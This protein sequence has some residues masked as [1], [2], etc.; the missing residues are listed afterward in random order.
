MVPSS[1]HAFLHC[2]SSLLFARQRAA[3]AEVP[4][5]HG[6]HV[7]ARGHPRVPRDAL[8]PLRRDRALPRPPERAGPAELPRVA[9]HVGRGAPDMFAEEGEHLP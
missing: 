2:T 6:R 8:R 1:A 7:H 9:R 4:R 5:R 3:P